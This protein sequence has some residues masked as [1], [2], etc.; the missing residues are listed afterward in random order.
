M[1]VSRPI[2]GKIRTARYYVQSFLVSLFFVTPWFRW[3][4]LPLI[5]L[6][7]PERKFFL[8]GNI[9]TPQE[10]YFLHLFLIGMGLTLFF[11]TTLIGRVWCGWACPQTIYTDI[12]DWIGRR[13]Q[14]SKYG[15]KDAPTVPK[16]ITH[17]V[18]ILTSGLASAAWIA[19]FADPYL[20]VE[21]IRSFPVTG[22]IPLWTGF[23]GFFTFAMYA[24]IAFI[25]EQFCKYACPY[26]RFQTVMMDSHSVN[27]TYDFNRGEP[28]RQGKVKIGDCTACNLCLVVCPTGIDIREGT[29]VGCIAC[30]KCSDACTQTMAKEGKKT[31][32][33]YWSE[34]Q[35]V[36]KGSPIRWIR[37]RTIVYATGLILVLS[38]LS[39]LLWQRV[40]LYLS[41]LP[42]RNIQPL[43]LGQGNV[44][45][46]YEVQMQNLTQEDKVLKFEIDS[47]DL[48]GVKKILVGGTEEGTVE[49]P[50]NSD[51]RYRLFIDLEPTP[52]DLNKKSHEITLKVHDLKNP[53]FQKSNVVPF[54]L[55]LGLAKNE[56]ASDWRITN[57]QKP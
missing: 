14:G 25:R 17:I 24:D 8:F 37:T 23:L 49:L 12:F 18:W 44:R 27:I 53:G 57:A 6:D 54:L 11:F 47:T 15:K 20:M 55:P 1:I 22:T 45:N 2:S 9:F 5:R 48:K 43:S 42:D 46:F 29:N 19:Y 35:I 40:P 30:G 4:G 16:I 50:A 7:I 56:K 10:G 32:I 3:G 31:L 28:R 34:N 36:Q 38:V 33:G 13:I 51:R 52:E 26:A 21:A 39:L 41:V